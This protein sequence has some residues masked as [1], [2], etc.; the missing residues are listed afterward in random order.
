MP[1]HRVSAP[2]GRRIAAGDRG[3]VMRRIGLAALLL[4]LGG[5]VEAQTLVGSTPVVFTTVDSV[6]V[7][8]TNLFVTGIVQ[9][10]SAPSERYAN[11]QNVDYADACQK[12]ALLAMAKPGQYVLE[13][14]KASESSAY[15]YCRLT[16][17]TQ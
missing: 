7:Y 17:V 14:R 13:F 15:Y 1:C 10:E 4:A 6:Q 8:A 9:G 3:N 12:M 2:E 11:L 5:R 16:R